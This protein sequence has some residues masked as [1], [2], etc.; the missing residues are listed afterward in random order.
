MIPFFSQQRENKKYLN[1]YSNFFKKTLTSGKV[2][3]G[4]DVNLFE[5][6]FSKYMGCNHA[7]SVNSCTDALYFCL[8]ALNVEKNDEVIVTNLSYI[9]SASAIVRIG[10]K[11][12][13]VD[14]GNDYNLNLNLAKEKITKKTKAMIFVHLF[15]NCA[16]LYRLKK[17]S[18]DYKIP[19]IEDV[20]QA[21]GARF[22]GIKAGTIGKFGCF[23]FDPTKTLSAPGSGGMITTNSTR[24]AK[25]FKKIR[26]HG[27]NL[28][29]G[30]FDYNGYN[31]Q[32][33]TAIAKIL[34]F[35]LK[36]ND[37]GIV[38]RYKIAKYYNDELKHLCEVPNIDKD[39]YRHIF[40]KYVL[41][42]NNRNKLRNFLKENKIQTMI[43]YQMPLSDSPSMKKYKNV[44]EKFPLAK[45]FCKEFL[46]LPIHPFLKNNEV[47][48]VI[49][50]I[51]KFYKVNG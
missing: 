34:N 33:P 30:K 25:F 27:K 47:S 10:A 9:A 39:T 16:D 5:K 13:F 35:K 44:N 6:N 18:I 4:E 21:V 26:Y 2:L 11:P 12:V 38:S 51:K 43:H 45:K 23:S 40:H 49:Y 22:K 31:S 46:S 7:V 37:A 28:E 17:F 19:L 1:K 14:V 48:K 8:L 50:T 36:K 15:G 41:R 42:V 24:Y 20:A 29:T 32:L 3:Q